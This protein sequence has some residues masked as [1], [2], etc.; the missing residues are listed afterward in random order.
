MI[1][2]HDV[3]RPVT[4][5]GRADTSFS[6]AAK[7]AG[8]PT[9]LA[10]GRRRAR[11][12]ALLGMALPGSV[13]VYQGEELGLPE[14][15]DIEPHLIHDPMHFRSGGVDPGR[16]GAR[17][18]MPWSG[19]AAPFGFSPDGAGRAVAA[20][21]RRLGR[22]DR[23]GAER[24]PRLDPRAV[25]GRAADPPRRRRPRRRAAAVARR[26]PAVLAFARGDGFACVVNLSDAPV[27][28]PPHDAVLLASAPLA[29][30][31]RL[32][33]DAAAWLRLRP[34]ARPPRPDRRPT[35]TRHRRHRRTHRQQPDIAATGGIPRTEH[36]MRS[37]RTR[38]GAAL[39]VALALGLV[40]ACGDDDDGGGG[41]AAATSDEEVTISVSNLP[42][43]TEP[44]TRE[45]FMTRVEEFEAANPNI[46]IDAQEWE[47]DVTTFG[48]QLAGNTL[49]TTFEIPFTYGPTLIERGQL[50]DITAE[51]DELPY[52][53]EFNPDV[54]QAVED[55][56]KIYAVPTAAYGMGLHY[57]RAMFEA[58]GLDP[59]EPPTS[60]DEVR[61]YAKAISDATGQAGYIQMT[62]DSTGGWALTSVV[63]A[64]GGRVEDGEGDDVTA[65]LDDPA[66][67]EA[68]ETAPG[69]ALG[70]RLDGR[71][72]PVRLGRGEPGVRGRAGRHV[73]QRIGRL[74]QPRHREQRRSG[75]LRAGDGPA[76]R[77]R[78]RGAGRGHDRGRAPRLVGR[79]AVGRGEVDRLLL[80]VEAHRRGRR[81]SPTPRRSWPATVRWAR[82]PCRCST[83][84]SSPSRTGGSPTWSTCR[85][86]R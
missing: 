26:R 51:F 34:A 31:G 75:L 83:P 59:D 39:V 16:D 15:E 65:T 21:A 56:D 17:V 33:A 36:D 53:D 70:G 58:A 19:T 54:L 74:Q 40:A 86:T 66:V 23:R 29:E 28:L 78:R 27:D 24:R 67:K 20:A 3:T 47:W 25:P 69:H 79:R 13:Y 46:T 77:R 61:E 50:Q 8:T 11:A 7:R 82:R 14:V 48:S 12:A 64:M 76:R 38:I 44:E 49:P 42:P 60:W 9:D 68:L 18:P 57:N 32:P 30:G 71:Q 22:P 80:P 10:L 45:A 63:N 85:S 72:L 55:D 62:Q 41:D 52:A 5:Y 43:E 1:S 73:H 81:R 4:R 2:N 37:T 6:F 84:S 35:R